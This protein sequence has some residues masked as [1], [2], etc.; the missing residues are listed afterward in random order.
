MTV[1]LEVKEPSACSGKIRCN[2]I[3][4][5]VLASHLRGQFQVGAWSMK[6]GS[7]LGLALFL[8]KNHVKPKAR[9]CEHGEPQ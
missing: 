3:A 4:Y 9:N 6:Y 7:D 1:R 5:D 2:E 8:T